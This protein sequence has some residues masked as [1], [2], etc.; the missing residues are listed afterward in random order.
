MREKK[1]ERM[2]EEDGNRMWLP[3]VVTTQMR[4]S[5][6]R[7]TKSFLLLS[8][9]KLHASPTSIFTVMKGHLNTGASLCF[10]VCVCVCVY[11]RC[12]WIFFSIMPFFFFYASFRCSKEVASAD[13]ILSKA[14][15]FRQVTPPKSLLPS[16][17][18]SDFGYLTGHTSKGGSN[19]LHA[20]TLLW[21]RHFLCT[22]TFWTIF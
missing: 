18:K 16:T 12:A 13:Q 21:L 10:C 15:I 2:S 6:S 5:N 11:T 1:R 22:C 20:L 4:I 19:K 17:H 9:F 14:W 3:S 7:Y 8:V